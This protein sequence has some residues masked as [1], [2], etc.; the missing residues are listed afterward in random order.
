MELYINMGNDLSFDLYEDDDNEVVVSED[1]AIESSL[2]SPSENEDISFSIEDEEG[3]EDIIDSEAFS[4]ETP[5]VKTET[6]V[7]LPTDDSTDEPEPSLEPDTRIEKKYGELEESLLDKVEQRLL[8]SEMAWNNYDM[9][10]DSL[11]K[12]D[13]ITGG[14]SALMHPKPLSARFTEASIKA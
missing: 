11:E 6:E 2:P 9:I 7:A 8:D 5:I 4:S 13:E 3:S 1:A 10:V 14:Q 12:Q